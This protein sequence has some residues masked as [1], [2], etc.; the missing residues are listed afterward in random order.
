MNRCAIAMLLGILFGPV[1]SLSAQA[2][3]ATTE[4]EAHAIGVDA[5]VYFYS[6]I[7]AGHHTTSFHEHRAW[8]RTDEG[9]SKHVSKCSE[10][11]TR[12]P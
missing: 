10:L 3:T 11:P 5:Y 1:L 7:S 8:Q 4:E 9:T 12:R 2:Q 6:L